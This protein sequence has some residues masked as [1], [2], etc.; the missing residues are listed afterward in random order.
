MIG[1][2]NSRFSESFISFGNGVMQ[3]GRRALAATDMQNFYGVSLL[4]NGTAI[5]TNLLHGKPTDI[6]RSSCILVVTILK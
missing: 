5:F 4:N 1:Y 6:I 2:S 3:L